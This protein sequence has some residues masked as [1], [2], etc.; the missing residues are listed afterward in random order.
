MRNMYMDDLLKS[1]DTI[2]QVLM[3]YRKSIQLFTNSGFQ[4]MKWATNATE[5]YADILEEQR[6]PTVTRT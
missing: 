4:L 5:L 3:L 6:A 2:G 1:L